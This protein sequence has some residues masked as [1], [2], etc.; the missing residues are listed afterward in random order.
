MISGIR[1][2]GLIEVVIALFI[3][4]VGTLGVVRLQAYME[5]KSDYAVKSVQAIQIAES[6]LERLSFE[7]KSNA[8]LH[9]EL[10]EESVTHNGFN[11]NVRTLDL[12]QNSKNVKAV[13]VSLEVTWLSTQSEPESISLDTVL[14]Q[15]TN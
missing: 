5:Q 1:G 6:R 11:L 10:A 13:Y 9:T 3:T 14:S 4:S 7:I 2:S 8:Q 12:P 15:T